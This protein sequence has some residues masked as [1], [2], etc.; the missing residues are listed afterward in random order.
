MSS[1]SNNTPFTYHQDAATEKLLGDALE[2]MSAEIAADPVARRVR[3]VVL[4]GGYGRG[5]GGFTV[6]HRPYNDL[7]FLVFPTS[8]HDCAALRAAFKAI[9]VRWEATLGIEVDFFIVP[10]SCWL[11]RNDCT[12]LIQELLVGFRIVYGDPAVLHS[13]RR[14]PWDHTLLQE[15]ARLLLNRGTGLFL[16][17]MRLND[18]AESDF[19]DRNLHKAATGCGDALLIARKS[20]CRAGMERLAALQKYNDLPQGLVDAY[21]R[22]LEF[23]YKPR[24][25]ASADRAALLA[26]YVQCFLQSLMDFAAHA[27]GQSVQTPEKAACILARLPGDTAMEQL[28]NCVR[29]LRWGRKLNAYFPLRTHPR[30]KLLPRLVSALQSRMPDA[31]YIAH[32]QQLN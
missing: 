11:R 13:A 9:S 7:D 31:Q 19:I 3:A 6:D 10:S 24:H 17:G 29:S 30:L 21:A 15:G 8:S 4:G 27:T 12:L 18:P 28:R 16:A 20:Y 25:D 5:E 32:W 26:A 1:I 22:G 14:R 2:S 23:K